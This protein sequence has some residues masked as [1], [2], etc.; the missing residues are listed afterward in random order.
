MSRAVGRRSVPLKNMCS[1]K[2][3]MPFE[4]AVS[5][6]EPAASMTMHVTDC[7]Y[8]RSAVRTRRPLSRTC[9]R[10]CSRREPPSPALR[11]RPARSARVVVADE[12]A[13][14]LGDEAVV[15][16]ELVL[17]LEAL[18]AEARRPH[19]DRRP[20]RPRRAASGSRSPSGRGSRRSRASPRRRRTRRAAPARGTSSRRRCSRAPCRRGRGSAR[21]RGARTGIPPPDRWYRRSVAGEQTKAAIAAQ[22]EWLA[23][24]P[25]R[26]G[27]SRTARGSSSP[28]AAP[29][30]TRRRRAGRR[31]RR[32]SSCSRPS[33]TPT[34]SSSSRTRERRRSRSRRRG[35]GAGRSGSSPARPTARSPSSATR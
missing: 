21:S 23:P 3:A 2:C 5:Y 31:F 28:A 7:A 18:R 9:A 35:L 16:A 4:S 33:A 32:S 8:G 30:S 17:E 1:A 27:A 15:R 12:D 19:A 29:R 11:D 6:R 13:L 20:S 25:D 10:T 22:P 24:G 34:C 26:R 14:R